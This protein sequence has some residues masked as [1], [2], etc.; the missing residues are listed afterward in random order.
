M[1]LASENKQCFGVMMPL[2]SSD[3]IKIESMSEMVHRKLI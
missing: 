3:L 1:T 2:S